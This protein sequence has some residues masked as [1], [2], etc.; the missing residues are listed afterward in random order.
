[1]L[2]KQIKTHICFL[3]AIFVELE[4][5]CRADYIEV[6]VES[7]NYPGLDTNVTHLEDEACGPFYKDDS[8]AVFR[9]GLEECKTQQ[10][11]DG[12]EIHYK[13]RIIA[14]VKDVEKEEH[15]TRK[16]TRVLPFQCSYDKKAVLSKVFYSP[17]YIQMITETG[18]YKLVTL[19]YFMYLQK[20]WAI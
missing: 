17:D 1:M 20:R 9:F 3:Y 8:K 14:V 19:S 4:V 18:A 15:I 2:F 11:D 16:S 12:K 10:E 6:T 13:N 7:K 5:V